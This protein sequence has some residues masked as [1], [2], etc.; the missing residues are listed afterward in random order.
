MNNEDIIIGEGYSLLLHIKSTKPIYRSYY[1][2][3]KHYDSWNVAR[4][5]CKLTEILYIWSSI[6]RLM[7]CG[8]TDNQTLRWKKEKAISSSLSYQLLCNGTLWMHKVKANGHHHHRHV[9]IQDGMK[10]VQRSLRCSSKISWSTVLDTILISSR[11]CS[12]YFSYDLHVEMLK[13]RKRNGLAQLT[14]KKTQF[15]PTIHRNNAQLTYKLEY[16]K[17]TYSVA[18]RL[19]TKPAP[20]QLL[21][22]SLFQKQF[23]CFTKYISHL[24]FSDSVTLWLCSVLLH[25]QHYL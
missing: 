10:L 7:Q 17:K 14:M 5:S 4:F 8:F 16:N 20:V 12:L 23:I 3:P 25:L 21:S 24:F 6:D 19:A 2:F 9:F 15:M 13:L 18:E 11:T 22:C 1:I